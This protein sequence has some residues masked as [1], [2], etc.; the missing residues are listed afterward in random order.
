MISGP[1]GHPLLNLKMILQF[2]NG[3]THGQTLVVVKS[4]SRLKTHSHSQGGRGAL[5][6]VLSA[7][8]TEDIS[9]TKFPFSRNLLPF[10]EHAYL[11]RVQI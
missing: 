9:G 11:K 5:D 8:H 1:V 4:L 6:Q 3:Q 7:W 10:S 2:A